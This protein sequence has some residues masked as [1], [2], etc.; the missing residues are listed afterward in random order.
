MRQSH[1]RCWGAMRNAAHGRGRAVM[2]T[3]RSRSLRRSL[4]PPRRGQFRETAFGTVRSP[5]TAGA[6]G[7]MQFLPATWS[8]YGLGGDIDD[9]GTQSSE[10]PTTSAPLVYSG[11]F[12]V[13]STPTTTR[14]STSTPS[15]LMPVS[16][17]A[18]CGRSMASTPGRC[19]CE[20]QPATAGSLARRG[21][22]NSGA[23]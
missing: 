20:R 9:P 7:P 19:S 15:S 12:V 1:R 21:R 8:A 6:R 18:T 16:C 3:D 14:R 5:S 22:P 17:I 10:P 4:A 11:I 23:N 2:S 13:R